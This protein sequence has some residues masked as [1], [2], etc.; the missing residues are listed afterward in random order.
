MC[1]VKNAFVLLAFFTAACTTTSAGVSSD[2]P[3]SAKDDDAYISVVNKWKREATVFSQFQKRVDAVAVLFTDEFRRAY[4][5]RWN[6]LR[7]DN[8]ASFEEVGA[9]KMAVL[10][11]AYTPE[12]Q[13]SFLDN[14]KLWSYQLKVADKTLTP[15]QISHLNDK[16]LFEAFFPF[17]N[18]WTKEYLVIFETSEGGVGSQAVVNPTSVS[19]AMRSAL[20]SL[21]FEWK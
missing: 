12:Y 8:R 20:V 3:P 2:L 9:N 19:F 17:I 5:E 11:S 15:Y 14:T 6:R 7:A 16:A 4:A 10:V 1:H 13:Y 18:K 21:N